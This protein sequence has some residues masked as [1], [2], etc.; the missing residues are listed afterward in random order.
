MKA[1]GGSENE[2]RMVFF[3]EAATIGLIGAF[4]GLVLGWIVTRI[5]NVIA[6]SQFLPPGEPPIDFFYFPLW[7]ILGAV[8]FSIVV[9]LAAGLYPAN[10]A[11]RVD[12]VKALR[13]D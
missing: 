13:H 8:M 7:L 2:I 5:A 11:A 6:N 4:F 10:R 3:V 1:I 12:P 9:S